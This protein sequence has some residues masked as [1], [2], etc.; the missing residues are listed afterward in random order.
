[1][2]TAERDH[3]FVECATF[4]DLIKPKGGTWQSDWHFADYPYLDE[5]G[6]P[7]DYPN[8][9]FDEECVDKAIPYIVDWLM[10]K[11]GY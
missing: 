3:P 9:H 11:P 5:G 1:M 8:Y 7:D 6:S 2:V 10:N 4:A